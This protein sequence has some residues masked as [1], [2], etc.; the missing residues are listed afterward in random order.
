LKLVL[1]CFSGSDKHR[2]LNSNC[3]EQSGCFLRNEGPAMRL[4]TFILNNLDVLLVDWVAFARELQPS[5]GNIDHD[6][7]L[8]HGRLILTVIASDM[9]TPQDDTEQQDK[10]EGNSSS[11]SDSPHV[12]ARSHARQRERQGFDIEELVAEYRALRAT[13]L[14]HW[15]KVSSSTTVEDLEDITR[16]NEAVDQAIA[17]SLHSFVAALDKSRDLF[18]GVLGHDLRGPLGVIA[19]IA[20]FD[21]RRLGEE[22]K[23]AAIVMRSVMH[24]K[25]LLD[26]LLEYANHRQNAG[27]SIKPQKL[28]LGDFANA[29][30]SEIV[31]LREGWAIDLKVEGDLWGQ[32]DPRRMHQAISNLIFN[33][34]KYGRP[35]SPILISLDG[36]S[37]AEVTLAVAN[38]G[39]PIPP[40]NFA[41]LFDPFVRG[42]A[43]GKTLTGTWGAGANMGLGLFIVR[44]IAQAHGGT[45]DVVSNET[46]TRFSIR[47]PRSR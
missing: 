40:E 12:P 10:S 19:N 22:A 6:G 31:A 8:D 28:H 30:L 9:Q 44:T 42:E 27:L 17:E 25:A 23:R 13:V 34:L 20:T 14:R 45:V 2:T 15:A 5:S 38:A 1:Q 37:E 3:T 33:A 39:N 16:F 46:V 35:D 24:M 41:K 26:D 21:M 43:G 32:W 29:V 11:A 7:L 4:H 36:T 47:L 18:L